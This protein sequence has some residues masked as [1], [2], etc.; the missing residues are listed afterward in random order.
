MDRRDFTRLAC[1]DLKAFPLQ[2][3]LRREPGWRDRPAAVVAQ[4]KP[5]ARI[6][7][8][9]EKARGCGILPG[10]RY[11][12]GLGLSAELCAGVVEEKE[13]T[14]AIDAIV[15]KLRRFGPDVESDRSEPG[16]FWVS[17]RGL[18]RLQRTPRAW[19]EAMSRA[20]ARIRFDAG[21][22]VGST[23]F[24]SYA[25]ARALKE[26]VVWV[27][28]NAAEEHAS[29]RRV[30]LSRLPIDAD[31]RDALF[32]LGIHTLGDLLELP[33]DG[34][35]DRFGKEA[36]RLHQ[37]ARSD[38]SRIVQPEK[39]QLRLRESMLLDY[40]EKDV[41]RLM[42]GIKRM[43]DPLLARLAENRKA[44]ATLILELQLERG[45]GLVEKLKPADPT[46]DARQLLDLLLLRFEALQLRAGVTEMALQ[47]E[48]VPATQKQLDLFAAQPKRDP[49]AVKRSFARLRAEFGDGA[50]VRAQL[51]EGH[52]PEGH[53]EWR[54]L[55]ELPKP[56][57]RLGRRVL[58]RRLRTR[59]WALPHR[60]RHEED[61]WQLRGRDDA[62]VHSLLG[63]FVVS[64]GWW[65]NR[66]AHDLRRDYYF[67]GT[68]KG[69]WLWVYRDR[70][71]RRWFLHG[72]VE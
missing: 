35:H 72:R 71:K 29:V 5:N 48:A 24:G 53:Y 36:Y 37:L 60:P 56:K 32:A 44:L 7:W 55:R 28:R 68:L 64:G 26:P 50:V 63:P 59:P 13:I 58:I 40:E 25:L 41:S 22:V 30:A 1:I 14:R 10:M 38:E 27:L 11:A 51:C 65:R 6:L 62:S 12:A 39:E 70:R 23:R 18:E 66:H 42:F 20:L 33:P 9:N 54:P 52:L 61:G 47:V 67:A 34:L 69:E 19:A 16:L 4:D 45:P 31:A 3:L 57:P 15:E 43:L 8:L 46:L 21:I 17:A 49:N 2:L